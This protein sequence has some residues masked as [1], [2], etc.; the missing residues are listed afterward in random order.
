LLNKQISAARAAAIFS[1]LIFLPFTVFAGPGLVSSDA[2]ETPLVSTADETL[3]DTLGISANGQ[4]VLFSDPGTCTIYRKDRDS[5]L[6]LTVF[7]NSDDGYEFC[8]GAELSDDGNLVAASPTHLI[9]GGCDVELPDENGITGCYLGDV[10]ELLVKNID[11]GNVTKIQ[12]AFISRSAW[13]SD[14]FHY[15]VMQA[16][17]KASL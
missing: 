5:G 14:V 12:R 10:T 11:T 16:F 4:Y 2:T 15:R 6:L 7:E 3:L 17:E 13:R 9:P 1:G 8:S